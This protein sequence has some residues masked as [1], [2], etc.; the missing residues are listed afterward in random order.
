[1]LNFELSEEQTMLVDAINR[2]ATERVRKVYRDAD[3]TSSPPEDVVQIGWEIGVLPTTIP[4]QYGGF[5]EYSLVTG[6]L[7]IEAFAHGDLSIAMNILASNAVAVPIMLAGTDAQQAHYLPLFCDTQRPNI[8]VAIT[9]PR[10]QYDPRNLGTTATA[11]GDH[12]LLNGQKC[13]VTLADQA[14][15]L[16]VYAKENDK[17][18]A[19]FVSSDTAGLILGEREK[20]MGLRSLPTHRVTFDNCRI[21][22]ENKLG[23]EA[24]IDIDTILTHSRIAQG[25]AAVGLAQGAHEYAIEYAKNREQFG[26]PIAHRQ[27][28]AFMLAD[29][30]M[31]ISSTRLMVWE[32]AWLL[33]Q[34]QSALQE[35]TVLKQYSDDMVL[36]VADQALQTLGGHGYIREYPVELWFRN[37]RSF[38]NLDGL[39]MV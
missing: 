27:S 15:K 38:V 35:T 10:I 4:E 25:A 24:G 19:F 14:D 13:M 34:G 6:A 23:G 12:Y 9:E 11:D 16:L 7:A 39:L 31:D 37:A 18:Q 3:E 36:R 20:L 26:E 8:T 22:T 2:F 29:M 1:M 28:I 30:A 17:T 21:P 33:D 32:A 5:G